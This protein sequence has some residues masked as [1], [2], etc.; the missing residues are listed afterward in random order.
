MRIEHLAIWAKNIE[1]LRSFYEEYFNGKAGERYFNPAKNFQSY[2]LSFENG[3]RLELMQKREVPDNQNVGEA[4]GLTHF[5]V[6]V[7]GETAVNTMTE[8]LRSNGHRIV[9]EPR[10]TG[11]GYY[12][13][14]VLDPEGNRIEICA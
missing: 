5:A 9:G 13:S 2:F 8:T 12:E 6:S 14:V 1:A 4:T 3:C 7:G 11:D 10:W